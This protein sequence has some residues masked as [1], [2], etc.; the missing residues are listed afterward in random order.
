MFQVNEYRIV[1]K[2]VWHESRE[3]DVK[4]TPR[5]ACA[6][7]TLAN[8]GRYDTICEI[9]VKDDTQEV[10]NFTGIAKLH[11][12]DT[13]DKIVGKKIALRNAIGTWDSVRKE[14][15]Y[16]CANFYKKGVRIDIWKAFWA[17]VESWSRSMGYSNRNK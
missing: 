1:F 6:P 9:Y 14:W 8:D 11:P 7:G 5:L 10:P 4:A 15:D 13:P 16:N 12:N 2:R 17:W 3:I